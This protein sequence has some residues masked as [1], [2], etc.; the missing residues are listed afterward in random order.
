M[1]KFFSYLIVIVITYCIAA[2]INNPELRQ[3]V[4]NIFQPKP[5]E[6][7][8]KIMYIKPKI[9][10]VTNAPQED[11]QILG[12]LKRNVEVGVI[13]IQNEWAKVKTPAGVVGWVA[14]NSLKEEKPKEVA[15]QETKQQTQPVQQEQPQETTTQY[16]DLSGSGKIPSSVISVF[17]EATTQQPQ[18]EVPEVI[19]QELKKKQT[20][21][22]TTTATQEVKQGHPQT[23]EN[24]QSQPVE[25]KIEVKKRQKTEQKIESSQEETI[26]CPNC[27]AEV[28]KG[29]R[30]CPYCR[31][32]LPTQ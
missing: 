19:K 30:F 26:I 20:T 16:E 14:Y 17:D 3:K 23:Q 7:I 28:I 31:E 4:K 1:K 8:I 18:E 9:A 32:P 24:T 10:Y 15:K 11:A 2:Y 13:E 5:K 22:T 12:T 6:T 29:E 27:G 25:Q 21:T